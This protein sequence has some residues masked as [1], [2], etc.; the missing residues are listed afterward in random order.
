M[1]AL[2]VNTPPKQQFNIYLPA[3]LIRRIKHASVDA[4]ESLSAFVERVLDEYL[5]RVESEGG[6]PS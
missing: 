6:E 4:N 5:Q 1:L 3:D 2:R